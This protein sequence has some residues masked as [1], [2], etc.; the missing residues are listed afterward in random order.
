MR[1]L[2]ILASFNGAKYISE[3]IQ[4]ILSQQNVDV[5]IK[6]F[7]D[8]S[9]DETISLI[10]DIDSERVQ[11]KENSKPTGSAALN[12][13]YSLLSLK[14]EELK[15]YDYISFADQDDIWLPNK[16]ESAYQA[17]KS[18]KA[19]LY[20]S[21]LI[22]WEEIANKKSILKRSFPQKRFDYLFEGGSAG[23][24]YVFTTTFCLDLRKIL[25][26]SNISDWR[27]FSHDWFVYFFARYN[28]YKVS[29]DSSAFI[30][31]RIHETNVHGQLNT[32]S[33]FSIIERFK[34]IKNGWFDHQIKGFIEFLPKDSIEYRIYCLYKKNYF[35]RLYVLLRYN[36]SLMRSKLKF[37][38]F[39][40]LSLIPFRVN[41]S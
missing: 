22:L 19:D 13:F 17:L 32:F 36:F 41:H 21:N 39:F 31:Y 23:C 30:L 4:S 18:Q 9:T 38:K 27:F 25:S 16:L 26:T 34:L 10:N 35:T 6:V 14:D 40:L 11:L 15:Q 20:M 33:I 12:F 24:T 2:V 29:F 8:G 37:I 3:Q 5:F 1:I 7:D 28:K